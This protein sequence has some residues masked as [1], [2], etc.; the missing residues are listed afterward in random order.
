MKS[1]NSSATQN[2]LCCSITPAACTTLAR[3]QASAVAS[4]SMPNFSTPALCSTTSVSYLLTAAPQPVLKCMEQIPGAT[5][6]TPIPPLS[7][8]PTTHTQQFPLPPPPP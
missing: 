2:R 4:S 3:S 7:S 1:R 8:T 6:S 5:S